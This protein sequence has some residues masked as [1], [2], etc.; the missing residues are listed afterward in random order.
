MASVSEYP[1]TNPFDHYLRD[2]QTFHKGNLSTTE[3]RAKLEA[4]LLAS[5]GMTVDKWW[6][7]PSEPTLVPVFTLH[8]DEDA[9]SVAHIMHHL[10]VSQYRNY[11]E[12][13]SSWDDYNPCPTDEEIQEEH[14]EMERI[15]FRFPVRFNGNEYMVRYT[16]LAYWKAVIDVEN[17]SVSLYLILDSILRNG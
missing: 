11:A 8:N 6:E 12:V 17:V 3:E 1:I 9:E 7:H 16:P 2:G 5:Y 10:I 15:M 14:E 4:D 13:K